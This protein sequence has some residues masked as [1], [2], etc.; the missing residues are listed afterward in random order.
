[1][2]GGR[3]GVGERG[4]EVWRDCGKEVRQEGE[5]ERRTEGKAAT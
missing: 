4:M 5:R 2:D 1:M 3:E